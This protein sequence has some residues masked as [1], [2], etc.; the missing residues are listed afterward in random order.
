MFESRLREIMMLRAMPSAPRR[1]AMAAALAAGCCGSVLFA[2]A[3]PAAIILAPHRAIYDLKLVRASEKRQ[4]ETVRGRILYDFSGSA[5]EGYALQFR[6]VSELNSGQGRITLS[7][8]RATTWEAADAKSFHFN[9]ENFLDEKPQETVDGDAERKADGIAV[10]LN[11]PEKKSFSL[12][13][14]LAFPAEH[15][16]RIIEAAIAGKNILEFPVYDGSE[17]G[18]KTFNT[19]TVIGHEIAPGEKPA[20]NDA[21]ADNAEL[22][23]LRRWPVTISYFERTA[24]AD[25]GEQTP[26]YSIGFELYENGVSRALS[27][28]YGDFV[29][30]GE[31]SQFDLREPK[32]CSADAGAS[33]P[34]APA[35]VPAA[36]ETK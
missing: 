34:K 29:V 25:N 21:A 10:K 13:A 12:D 17:T 35:E 9:S 28:D 11:K 1:L 19:L 23:K 36:G 3:A 26:S 4:L 33:A 27:L 20:K 31:M 2:P 32:P 8:L 15:M 7:D 6:Q 30:S 5:C 16:R 22:A 14:G 18:Q 24:T